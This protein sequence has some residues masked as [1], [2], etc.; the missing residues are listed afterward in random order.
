V[1]GSRRSRLQ[2]SS[3]LFKLSAAFNRSHGCRT[4]SSR[5]RA[6]LPRRRGRRRNAD[7]RGL[8]C[9]RERGE[10]ECRSAADDSLHRSYLEAR[11]VEE[12]LADGDRT[13]GFAVASCGERPQDLTADQP[14]LQG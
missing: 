9:A 7:G 11:L 13:Q 2:E 12:A 5:F 8:A 14:G 6:F 10:A 4:L 3:W 1:T